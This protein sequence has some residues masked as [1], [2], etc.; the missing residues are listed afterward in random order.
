MLWCP[1]TCK[2]I[3]VQ[4]ILCCSSRI[5]DACVERFNE[6][7]FAGSKP[8]LNLVSDRQPMSLNFLCKSQFS[9]KQRIGKSLSNTS[10]KITNNTTKTMLT[11]LILRR[12]RTLA[13]PLKHSVLGNRLISRFY[14]LVLVL[15]IYNTDKNTL[16]HQFETN[17][18]S[19]KARIP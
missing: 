16:A 18:S 19:E 14:R 17:S 5:K 15:F 13:C 4:K 11:N 7:R 8:L 2:I 3:D 9:Y 6:R 12:L 10:I 1:S